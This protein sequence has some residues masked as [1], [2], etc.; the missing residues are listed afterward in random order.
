MTTISHINSSAINVYHYFVFNEFRGLWCL[1]PLSIILQLY[2]DSQ[3]VRV[4]E[5]GV[6][7][8][9]HRPDV[10]SDRH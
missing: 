2:R 1:M 4:E 6:P 10:S 3:F 9:N 7:R 5:T 8:E